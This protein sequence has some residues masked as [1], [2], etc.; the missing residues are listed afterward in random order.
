LFLDTADPQ[1]LST[2]EAELADQLATLKQQNLQL[3]LTRGKPCNEQLSLADKLDGLLEG[4]Y[5]GADGT[6]TRNYGGLDGLPEAKQLGAAL[7]EVDPSTVLVGG[8][9]SLALMFFTAQVGMQ[10]GFGDK[11]SAWQTTRAKFICPVP[12]YDRHFSVCETL[13]IDMVTVPMLSTGP[14]MDLVEQLV[15]KDP[16]IKGLWCVPKY[17]NPTGVIYSD[18]TVERI[19]KLGL[20]AGPYFRVFW[21]NAYAVHDLTETPKSLANIAKACAQYG[22]EDSVIQFASTSKITHAGAGVSFLAT[23]QANLNALKK[24]LGMMTIGPDKVNQLRHC[25]LLPDVNAIAAHMRKHAE[26]IR[27]RF[28]T[29]LSQLEK[30]LGDSD[31]GTWEKPQGG[32]FISFD[33]RPNCAKE[34]VKLAAETGVKLTPAGATFP[35]GKDPDDKNIR[36]APTV[37]SVAELEKAMDVFVTCVKLV[38]VRNKLREM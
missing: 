21:D 30:H 10:F 13:G 27:P 4:N 9:S 35:H 25:K 22:T 38:S 3:D 23:S 11:S 1:Q 28:E 37:P 34:I 26:I 8:N 24:V 2:W 18:D 31:L 32:Y 6:D 33:T 16:T 7:L 36:I 14:D 20:I 12:G 15:A 19:A 17:S 29:V 5:R